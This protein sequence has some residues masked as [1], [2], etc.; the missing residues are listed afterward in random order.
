[1]KLKITLLLIAFISILNINAQ[2]VKIGATTYG[3]I[4]EAI[5]AANDGD[6]IEI[7]GI[8]TEPISIAK[9]ITLKGTD[10]TTDIIQAA[11]SAVSDGS[12]ERVITVAG[13]SPLALNV[14]IENLGIRYGN[15]SANGG[16]INIDKIT[17]LVTLKNLIIENNFSNTNGGAVGIAGSNVDIVQCTL[18]NNGS[19][20]DGGAILAAPNNAS[21]TNIIVNIKQS[22]INSNNGRNGGGI[23]I[24]GNNNFGNNYKIDV[25]IEN[26]TI[27]NNTTFSAS[28]GNG[29]GA[30]YV[31]SQNLIGSNPLISNVTLKLVHAT[32]YNNTH[33]AITKSGL[34]FGGNNKTN[35]SAFNSIIVGN[36]DLSE[37]TGPK[38]INFANTN[39]TDIINCILGGLNAPITLVDDTAKNNLKGKTATQAGLTGALTSEGG[40]TQVLAITEGS[41][42]DDFCTA[43]VPF[44]LPTIDQRGATR[45]GNP[46]AGAY[47]FGGVLSTKTNEFVNMVVYPNPAKNMVSVK[48][49]SNVQSLELF[50]ILGKKVKSVKNSNTLQLEGLSKGIY[51]LT[52]KNDVSSETKKIIIE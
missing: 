28:T 52:I 36:D 35:F 40:K 31:A 16:G 47:E 27:S 11:A 7:T 15:A 22:L 37:T 6:I 8:H 42:G 34:Q 29:G 3:T 10:P 18:K 30:I 13:E 19:A 14:T 45:E 1:M 46:D 21:S 2:T 43:T 49:V 24:N 33:A 38:A 12:G 20:L 5:T 41:S 25:N 32:V 26:S 50:S 51:M 17:T 9:S 44:S 39:T 48:G 23:Y 4:T